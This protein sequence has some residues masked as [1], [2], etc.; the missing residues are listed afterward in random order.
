LAGVNPRSLLPA[1]A[2]L[3]LLGSGPPAVPSGPVVG[4]P[5]PDFAL[6]T[7][8]GRHLR[9]GDYRGRTLVI[10]VW[11]S[12]CPPCRLETPDL[13]AE[14]LQQAS[15]GVAFLGV[16][17][18]EPAPA[19]RAFA[20]AKGVPYPQAAVAENSPFARDY[21]IR[22]YPTTF[23][24]GPDGVLRARHADNLLP[25]AQLHAYIVA[26]QSGESAPLQSAFQTQLDALLDPAQYPFSGDPA[27][28]RANVERA[29]AAIARSDDLMDEAMVDL[30][31][32]HDLVATQAEQ[33]RLRD[34]A[35]AAFAPLAR[36]DHDAALLARL[37]GDQALARGDWSDA[38]SLYQQAID[39]APDDLE[40]LAGAAYAAGER[41]DWTRVVQ[42]R[43]RIAGAA[44]SYAT[45]AGLGNALAKQADVA[46]AEGAYARAAA[47]AKTLP[48][49]AWT[50]LY[51]GR[52]EASL[53]RRSQ[54]R[55]AFERALEAAARIPAGDP[56]ATWYVEQA[57]EGMIAL[58]VLA[59]AP[60]SISLAPWTGADLPGSVA[61]TIKYRLA[62]TGSRGQAIG[63]AV[64]GL[65]PHWIGSFCTDR[66][67][68]PFHTQV[69]IPADGVKIVEFQVIPFGP[70]SHSTAVRVDAFVGARRVASAG[71]A[72]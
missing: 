44:P 36:D 58:G 16:D 11:G 51:A 25:R 61:S 65:P 3:M 33:V 8:D 9:L 10:N 39:L 30:T 67:C 72:V 48:A 7:L 62:V 6:T 32:D 54:A 40:A 15:H 27:T 57:Q 52:M 47:L 28:V 29:V 26:A 69:T 37:R 71:A 5:A 18:T 68:A 63:L 35:L 17:T 19:V 43:E 1:L 24:I 42:L 22:N 60:P 4:A 38:Q 55:A 66:V 21:D 13:I 53:G 14:A 23:V 45:F 2:L 64:R 12:W 70:A 59:G 46:A 41:A 34:A 49:R 31:R 56:R 20:A 50:N